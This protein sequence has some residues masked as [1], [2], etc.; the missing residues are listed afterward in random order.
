MGKQLQKTQV[1]GAFG[2]N[3]YFLGSKKYPGFKTMYLH[4]Y[5][6]EKKEK[7]QDIERQ[8]IDRNKRRNERGQVKK[9]IKKIDKLTYGL[10]SKDREKFLNK[11]A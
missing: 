1:K 2:F 10:S 7:V 11:V 5:S 3:G 8:R 9:F 4:Q 6:V